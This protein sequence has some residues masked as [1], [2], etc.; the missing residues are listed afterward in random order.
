MKSFLDVASPQNSD[1][2]R[3][4]IDS[5]AIHENP[6]YLSEEVC[7]P[8][9]SGS[10]LVTK[11]MDV[12]NCVQSQF[13]SKLNLCARTPSG[14]KC[15]RIWTLYSL[16]VYEKAAMMWAIKRVVWTIRLRLKQ[17]LC[18]Y[19]YIYIFSTNCSFKLVASLY[20]ANLSWEDFWMTCQ[21]EATE[22]HTSLLSLGCFHAWLRHSKCEYHTSTRSQ[23]GEFS[24]A[25][26]AVRGKR[27]SFH[28][29]V[30]ENQKVSS[31]LFNHHPTRVTYRY[32]RNPPLCSVCE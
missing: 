14:D 23:H 2:F 26:A 10:E 7:P 20:C 16:V 17:G 27:D 6:L 28:A 32:N 25:S 8:Q 24:S 29:A 5:F 9:E 15:K 11:Y 4:V 18:R 31:S 3:W 22:V 12:R 21:E 30:K 1:S 13:F 19:D